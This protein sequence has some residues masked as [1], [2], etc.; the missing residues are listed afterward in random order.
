MANR[1]SWR[2]HDDDVDIDD[3]DDDDKADDDD[4]DDN[5]IHLQRT[6]S[7][8]M[9]KLS[10]LDLMMTLISITCREQC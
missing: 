8:R 6:M 7:A 2:D 5:G 1:S 4:N 10:Q 9:G 3:D